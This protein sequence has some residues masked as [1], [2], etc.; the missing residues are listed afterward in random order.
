MNLYLITWNN[1]DGIAMDWFVRAESRYRAAT[2]WIK[3]LNEW[4]DLEEEDEQFVLLGIKSQANEINMPKLFRVPPVEG[5]HGII[6]WPH[7]EVQF[8][9]MHRNSGEDY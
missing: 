1:D 7:D 3:H 4:E 6:E 5:V 9:A 8:I 2:Y